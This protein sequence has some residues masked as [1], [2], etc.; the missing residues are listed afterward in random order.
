MQPW[1]Q[2]EAFVE[3]VRLGGFSAAARELEVSTS[4]ISRLIARLEADLGIQLLYRTT[5]Q[6]SL[7]EAG[8]VY[9]EH[10]QHLIA[11]FQA[12]RAQIR[13]LQASPRGLLRLTAGTT[14]G[15]RY[16]APLVHNFMLRYPELEVQMHFT[17]RCVE[18]IE[19]GFDVA[20]R[21]GALNDSSLVAKRLWDRNE[22]VVAS[23]DY[24]Q[25]FPQPQKLTDLAQHQCLLGSRD[26]WSFAEQGQRREVRV[27]GRYQ[28]N[29]GQAV[30]DA[31]LKGLGLAQLPEYY[32][33]EA[34]A[35]GALISVLDAYQLRDSAVWVVYPHHRY[36]SPKVRLLI[37]YLCTEFEAKHLQA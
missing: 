18:L 28:A 3:V 13:D 2:T 15:E 23:P 22:R 30:L 6:V 26:K 33:Q 20:I 10:C 21:M 32:L 27:S 29:S 11:G 17:N 5:R 35:S 36:L 37:D 24:F 1:D 25:R 9:Y 34:L 16:I 4:H 31:A 14:F 8:R 19:E 12:A 7:T